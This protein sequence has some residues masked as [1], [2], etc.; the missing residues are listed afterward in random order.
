[1]NWHYQVIQHKD[2]VSL[3]EVITLEDDGRVGYTDDLMVEDSIEDLKATLHLMLDDIESYPPTT[4]EELDKP[5]KA[6]NKAS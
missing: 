1:M 4:T 2:Y 3:V 5:C 6:R